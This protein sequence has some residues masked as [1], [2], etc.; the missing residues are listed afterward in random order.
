MRVFKNP[1]KTH[2]VILCVS[3]LFNIFLLVLVFVAEKQGHEFGMALERRNLISLSDES[4]PDYW[5]RIGWTN[6]VNKLHSEFDVA[7]FGNSITRGSD[8]QFYFTDKKIINLGYSGDNITGMLRR[9]PMLQAAHP[10]KIFVMAGTNDIFHITIDEFSERYEKLLNAISDSLP[11][12]S[13]YL[14]S[15][16]P[17]NGEIKHG[18]PSDEKIRNANKRL[19]EIA[20]KRNLKYVDIYNAY[21]QDGKLPSQLTRDGI[22]LIPEHYNKWAKIIEPLVNE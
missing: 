17:M 22:H 20:N 16:L 2:K 11:Y 4:H 21:V 15:I 19:S 13:V 12:S 14:Q 9:V 10:K 1:I 5:A 18:C 3:V 8:F 6:T 7:F